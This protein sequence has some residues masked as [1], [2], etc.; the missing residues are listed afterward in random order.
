MTRL[1]CLEVSTS[2]YHDQIY[3]GFLPEPFCASCANITHNS[4][5][6]YSGTKIKTKARLKQFLYVWIFKYAISYLG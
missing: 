3:A 6:H 5:W 1:A 4:F 2:V